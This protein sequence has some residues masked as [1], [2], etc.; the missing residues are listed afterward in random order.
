M[1]RIPGLVAILACAALLAPALADEAVK[2]KAKKAE[3]SLGRMLEDVGKKVWIAPDSAGKAAKK[4][5]KAA[6][7]RDKDKEAAK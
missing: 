3:S 6:K 4:E 7:T 1:K 5:K 2:D